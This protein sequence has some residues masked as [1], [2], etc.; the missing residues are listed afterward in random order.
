MGFSPPVEGCLVKKGLQKGMSRGP[1]D[2]PP[3]GYALALHSV[4]IN[5][6]ICKTI[7]MT[8]SI[9]GHKMNSLMNTM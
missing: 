8:L 9:F 4:K 2:A 6:I 1:Q 5:F 7:H 3:P